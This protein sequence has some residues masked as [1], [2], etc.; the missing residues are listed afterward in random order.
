[1]HKF[2]IAF[3]LIWVAISA[4][5][6][7]KQNVSKTVHMVVWRGCEAACQGFQRF[8]E[9]RALPV[10]VIVTDI[11]KDKSKLPEVR[12]QLI[13]E[14]PDLVVT[15]GTSVSVGIIGTLSEFGSKTALGDIPV[16]FMIVADPI[17]SDIVESYEASG[18]PT[19]TGVRNRVPERVQ[20]NLM[21]SYMKP[22]KLGI[23]FDPGELNS[24]LNT[25]KLQAI[26]D[27]LDFEIEEL[28]YSTNTDGTISTEQIPQ[29]MADLKALGVDAIYVGSSSFNLENRAAFTA[30]AISEG[31]PIFSAYAQMVEDGEGLMA[32]AN[33]YVNVGKMAAGRV[34]EILF[35]KRLPGE[36]EITS[37]SRFSV[38]VNMRAARALDLYPPLQLIEFASIVQ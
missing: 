19:L 10:N 24:R 17:K 13:K 36:M 21:F 11:A 27:E 31:L 38:L 14:R 35:D 4:H 3:A 25:Q 8:F 9:D 34:N 30:A 5:A 20:L 29:R 28:A 37:L 2:L 6:Q 33:S 32:V 18:R 16:L 1:M 15:W 7:T 12:A 26:S 22:E 23:L